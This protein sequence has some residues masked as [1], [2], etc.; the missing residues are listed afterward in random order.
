MLKLRFEMDKVYDHKKVEDKIS[1]E[2][3]ATAED[4]KTLIAMFDLEQ[5]IGKEIIWVVG[6]TFEQIIKQQ[7]RL[8]NIMRRTCTQEMKLRPIWDWWFKNIGEKVKMGIG[9]RYDE[10]ERAERLSTSFKGIVGRNKNDT[11]T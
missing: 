2:F 3:I 11:R 8:P 1:K 9:F 6:K 5:K 4:D 7:Q 10:I